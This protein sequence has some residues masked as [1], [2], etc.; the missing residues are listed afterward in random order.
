MHV[1]SHEVTTKD[2]SGVHSGI[3]RKLSDWFSSVCLGWPYAALTRII[4]QC[5]CNRMQHVYEACTLCAAE[6][7][8]LNR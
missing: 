5:T 4:A 1:N 6:L 8:G 7:T 2:I 3:S